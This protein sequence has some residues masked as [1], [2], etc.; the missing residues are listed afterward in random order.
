MKTLLFIDT[1]ILLD[2]YRIRSREPGLSTLRHID[3]HH[4]ELI[5][6]GQV[7][8]E[9]MKNRQSVIRQSI[10]AVKNP[11]ASGLA[12]PSLLAQSKQSR[13][14]SKNRKRGDLRSQFRA[15]L[16]TRARLNHLPNRWSFDSAERSIL[17]GMP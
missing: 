16:Q 17:S 2:F 13:A 9:F 8:I 5:T 11:D 4:E 10:Q 6:T 14:L 1:N 7:E 12:L 15:A 3:R